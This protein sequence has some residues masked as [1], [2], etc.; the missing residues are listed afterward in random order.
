MRLPRFRSRIRRSLALLCVCTLCLTL[1]LSH[2]SQ[3]EPAVAQATDAQEL[4]QI[5]VDRYYAG[6]FPGAIEQWQFAYEV[7]D[8]TQ[9]LAALA[10]VSENLAR[11]YQQTGQSTEE[12]HYWE[13]A[14]EIA[15]AQEEHQ[16]LGQLKTAQA[17][18]YSRQGQHRRAIAILCGNEEWPAQGACLNGTAIQIA[19]QTDDRAG[20]VAAIGSLAESYRQSGQTK[21]ALEILR[22]GQKLSPELENPA[23]EAAILNSLG[24]T[25]SS[26]AQI[27]Y[28]RADL[29]RDENALDSAEVTRFQTQAH[30]FNQ[31]AIQSFQRS[32]ELSQSQQDKNTQLRALLSLIPALEQ[33]H[34]SAE[35][36]RVWQQ[37]Q[38]LIR[39]LPNSQLKAFGAIKLA[40]FLEKS[41]IRPTRTKQLATCPASFVKSQSADLLEQARKIGQD[42]NNPR[43]MAFAWGKLGNLDER[44]GVYDAALE[45]TQFARRAAEQAQDSL[46]LWEWQTGRILKAQKKLGEA[47]KAYAQAVESLEKVRSSILSA[48]RDL[49]FD[50]RDTVEPLYRQYATLK[51][52]AVP[53]AVILPKDTT[54]SKELDTALVAIDSLKVAELQNYFANDCVIVPVAQRVDEVGDSVATAVLSTAM[55][56]DHLAVILS[57]PD[58]SKK[59]AQ[60]NR[61]RGNLVSLIKRFRIDL[62]EGRYQLPNEYD[63]SPAQELYTILVKPFEA[64]LAGIKTLVFV[65]DGLLRSIPMAALHDGQGFLIEKFAVATT[66]SLTLTTPQRLDRPSLN[67]LLL[68]LSESSEIPERPFS[69]LPAVETELTT[70]S[71]QLPNSK[72]LLNEAF[73]IESLQQALKQSDYRILH[74]ATHGTFGFDPEE[75]FVVTGAKKPTENGKFYNET[76]TIGEL[77]NVIRAVNDPT[78]APIELLTLTA[79]ETAIGDDR[80]TLGLAGVAIRAGVRSAIATLWSVNADSPAE[81]ISQFYENL[82]DP[83]LTKAE[84]LQKAQV[85]MLHSDNYT[86]NHPFHWAP[87]ILIGNWL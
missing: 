71:Q 64:D 35:A 46:Y 30:E 61:A 32:Y 52:E 67:A 16:K 48:S 51:L 17:Q 36:D 7:Y 27:A 78:R 63:L 60:I 65:N 15:Q 40:D 42:L 9:D 73:S 70:V 6:D 29:A 75:N 26:L 76:L 39:Q 10:I 85:A 5:G 54:L 45:K 81:L 37:A 62:E 33:S 50:F 82:Q 53:N 84:A 3:S 43:V 28:Y 34:Q 58:N 80:A 8:A 47:A 74:I 66:P 44:C 87:F 18:G 2:P 79:C 12:I 83:T 57:L 11:A 55:F 41:A 19:E 77:E 23:L 25:L 49:Q 13:R 22:Q 56:Q 21:K 38:Q 4:V 31:E 14:I 72:I 69:E 59:F 24:N 20:R 68:G 86:N 1:W